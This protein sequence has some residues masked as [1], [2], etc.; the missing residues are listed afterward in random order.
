[1]FLPQYSANMMRGADDVVQKVHYVGNNIKSMTISLEASLKKL[2]TH[3]VDIFYVHFV[4][5]LSPLSLS[6][7][8]PLTALMA[9]LQW[10]WETSIEEIMNGLQNLVASGKVLYLV[11]IHWPADPTTYQVPDAELLCRVSRT[12]PHGSSPRRTSTRA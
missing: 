12:R 3:Y 4:R 7:G 11:R 10:D 6:L 5:P 1:M 2:R 9:S 8:R